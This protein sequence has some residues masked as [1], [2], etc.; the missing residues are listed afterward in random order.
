MLFNLSAKHSISFL[1][2]TGRHHIAVKRNVVKISSSMVQTPDPTVMPARL[3]R[4]PL[5]AA[6]TS[7]HVED[8]KLKPFLQRESLLTL[9]QQTFLTLSLLDKS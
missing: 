2:F 3:T 8:I 7:P 6:D 1:K 5:W 9:G 4:H